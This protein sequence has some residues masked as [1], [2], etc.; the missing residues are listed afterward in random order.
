MNFE[1]LVNMNA[2]GTGRGETTPIGVFQKQQINRKYENVLAFHESL[3]TDAIFV[4]QMRGEVEAVEAVSGRHQMEMSVN[5]E[6]T[7]LMLQSG[8]FISLA[9]LL[10]DNPAIC[11]DAKFIR[12]LMHQ[13]V[14]WAADF[15]SQGIYHVCF[16]PQNIFL[17]RKNNEMSLISHGSFY[18]QGNS[19]ENLY[20]G[21]EDYIAPEVM[22]G[23]T[24]DER[25]DVYSVGK[26]FCYIF[27]QT[28]TPAVY[29]KAL[30]KATEFFPEDRYDSLAN[31]EHAVL[32]RRNAKRTLREFIVAAILALLIVAVYFS[33]TPETGQT[34]YVKPAPKESVDDV[35]SDDG[36]D[37]AVAM[38]EIISDTTS[39]ITPEKQRQ[40]EEYQAKAAKIFRK[41]YEREADRI[42]SR[43]Y[44]RT[45]NGT[46]EKSFVAASQAAIKELAKMQTDIAAQAG[47]DPQTSQSIAIEVIE[48]V[49][50]RK[51]KELAK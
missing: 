43:V 35:L 26:L 27:S 5:E 19:L 46:N 14:E 22:S 31:M 45:G 44:T 4:S 49:T 8:N 18:L 2:A 11:A 32:R 9:Q 41:R 13:I 47:I 48:Q 15:H 38:A 30:E 23:G 42:L 12:E 25:C 51:Q 7:G 21:F 28:D 37:P 20:K 39:A 16:S 3:A 10:N 50:N 24:V 33:L 1:E 6:G 29:K 17:H 40:L 34:E 36:F